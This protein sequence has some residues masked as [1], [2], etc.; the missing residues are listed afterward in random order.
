MQE[1]SHIVNDRRV[2]VVGNAQSQA[3]KNQGP[4]ID[5]HDV[6]IRMNRAAGLF[7]HAPVTDSHGSRTDIWCVWDANDRLLRAKIEKFSGRVLHV[8]NEN[9]RTSI[10]DWCLPIEKFKEIRSALGVWLPSSG[11]LLLNILAECEPQQVDVYGFDF[12]RTASHGYDRILTYPHRFDIEED[13]CHTHIF[14]KHNF[15]LK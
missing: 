15:K 7:D 14:S 10:A 11:F 6:V 13:F 2:A 3:T 5:S 12:K 1:F 9:Q 4:E 8:S